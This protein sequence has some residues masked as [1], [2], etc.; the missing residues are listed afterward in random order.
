MTIFALDPLKSSTRSTA[1]VLTGVVS[2][3]PLISAFPTASFFPSRWK[4]RIPT[5][6]EYPSYAATGNPSFE[7]TTTSQPTNVD[8][9]KIIIRTPQKTLPPV[10]QPPTTAE[11]TFTTQPASSTPK[12]N[13]DSLTGLTFNFDDPVLIG[14]VAGLAWTICLILICLTAWYCNNSHYLGK[15]SNEKQKNSINLVKFQALGGDFALGQ[16]QQ[17]GAGGD[18]GNQYTEEE[19]VNVV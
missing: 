8:E 15:R 19:F 16:S 3:Q 13:A 1:D 14:V 18:D 4:T 9:L 2:G 5:N 11:P 6:T 10:S 12:F 7:P 17:A